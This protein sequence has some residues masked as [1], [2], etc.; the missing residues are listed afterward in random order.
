MLSVIC[1]V[2]KVTKVVKSSL[3]DTGISKSE[4]VWIFYHLQED[5]VTGMQKKFGQ[6]NITPPV[7]NMLQICGKAVD[8]KKRRVGPVSFDELQKQFLL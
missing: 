2:T 4:N 3:R 8:H 1:K 6:P 7:P 5:L